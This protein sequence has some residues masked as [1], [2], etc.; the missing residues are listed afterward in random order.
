MTYEDNYL[1][2]HGIVGMK[3]GIRRY[4]NPDGTLTEEGRIRYGNELNKWGKDNRLY[5]DNGNI[6][7]PDAKKKFEKKTSDLYRNDLAASARRQSNGS[8]AI[9][10]TANSASYLAGNIKD[11]VN[12]SAKGDHVTKQQVRVIGEEA[13]HYTNQELRQ[14]I[15]R[16]RLERDYD[17]LTTTTVY[18][19]DEYAQAAEKT[20]KA[21]T[22][23]QTGLGIVG[24]VAATGAAVASIVAAFNSMSEK[25]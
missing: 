2:H 7:D 1:A 3:W 9:S 14:I 5:D 17:S 21:I 15:E 13:S 10:N 18:Q 25:K 16:L 8:Q 22:A 12:K 20:E 11:L 19:K 4:Q 24:S 23:L 6:I